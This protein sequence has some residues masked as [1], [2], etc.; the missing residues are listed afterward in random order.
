MLST[1]K[2]GIRNREVPRKEE[3]TDLIATV[4]ERRV[5]TQSLALDADKDLVVK[6][7]Y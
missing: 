1:R 6:W 4:R 3:A 5:N 7:R 2:R